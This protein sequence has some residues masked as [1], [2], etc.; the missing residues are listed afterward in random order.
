[1]TSFCF[2]LE[3]IYT[4]RFTIIFSLFSNVGFMEIPITLVVIPTQ[5]TN[6]KASKMAT[7]TPV[8]QEKISFTTAVSIFL[9]FLLKLSPDRL[10][11][12]FFFRF[13]INLQT[14]LTVY[15][16]LQKKGTITIRNCSLQLKLF[17][18]FFN[19]SFFTNSV[20]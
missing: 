11:I 12:P 6:T 16:K 9:L 3:I 2:G 5:Y 19:F 1:M 7:K 15:N 14:L 10:A 8:I 20:S 4:K 13:Y 17:N 18:D